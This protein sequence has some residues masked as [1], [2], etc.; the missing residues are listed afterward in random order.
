MRKYLLIS[1]LLMLL[2][3]L[4]GAQASSSSGFGLDGQSDEKA[5]RELRSYM[6]R[7][8]RSRPSVALVLSGG[9]A[10]G[11]A[12]V[13][14]LRFMEQ[15]DIPVDVVI[16]TSIGGLVGGLYSVGY[17]PE[18]LDSLFRTA[19][20]DLLLS[21]RIARE[22]ITVQEAEYKRK[23]GISFPFFY[24]TADLEQQSVTDSLGVDLG[25]NGTGR[26][27]L[28]SGSSATSFK[29]R[30]VLNSLPSGLYSG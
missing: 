12:H 2:P 21:D 1:V 11:A 28:S 7:I 24:R 14:A 18:Y 29:R 15:L 27:N 6:K 5:L 13:G 25:G 16:G 3:L 30:N 10:K 19:N 17:T 26:L 23:Y 22:Y 4:A 20:W 9:G 8:H